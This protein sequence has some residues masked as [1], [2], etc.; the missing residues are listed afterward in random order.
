MSEPQSQWQQALS[1]ERS[2]LPYLNVM[3]DPAEI[4][5]RAAITQAMV[6]EERRQFRDKA[7][8]AALQ[9]LIARHRTPVSDE[10]LIA[11]EAYNIADALLAERD[12]R[13]AQAQ[14]L[15]QVE[16]E[17]R[18]EQCTLYFTNAPIVLTRT[19]PQ[20]QDETLTFCSEACK[21]TWLRAALQPR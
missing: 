20:R 5:H 19:R 3:D 6:E 4:A 7:A 8:L 18:C 9:G 17:K 1:A 10:G 21:D 15:A 2:T 16:A 14:A 13:G 12:R 11:K